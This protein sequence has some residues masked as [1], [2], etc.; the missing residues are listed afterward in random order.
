MVQ[1]FRWQRKRWFWRSRYFFG[2]LA[3]AAGKFLFVQRERAK[4]TREGVSIAGQIFRSIA[5]YLIL[6]VLI[7]VALEVGENALADVTV[8]RP[9][10]AKHALEWLVSVRES[11]SRSV[12]SL[13]VLFSITASVSGVFLGLYFT[14]IS[15]VA[16]SVF[17]RVPGNLR[18]LLLNEKVGNQ[19]IRI[20]G[21]LTSVSVILLGHLAYGGMPGAF[22][23][24]LVIVLGCFG[25]L[26]FLKLGMRAFNFFD[27]ASLSNSLFHKLRNNVWQSSANGFRWEDPSFQA[28]YQKLAERN[29]GTLKSLISYCTQD[30]HME[31][32]PLTTVMQNTAGFLAYYARL[33]S[34]IPSDSRWYSLAP[35][36]KSYFFQDSSQLTLVLETHTPVQPQMVPDQY[37]LEDRIVDVLL[38][39]IGKA[40]ATKNMGVVYSFFEVLQMHVDML[41]ANLEIEK[42]YEIIQRLTKP[43]EQYFDSPSFSEKECGATDLAVFDYYGLISMSLIL[44]F[45]KVVDDSSLRTMMREAGKPT[46]SAKGIYQN[47]IPPAL[48]SRIEYVRKGQDFEK[49]VEKKTISPDW[50]VR[51]LVLIRCLDLLKEAAEKS[52]SL[53]DDFYVKRS[54]KLLAKKRSVLAS[55]HCLRGLEMCSKLNAHFPTLKELVEEFEKGAKCTDLPPP[56]WNWEQIKKRIDDSH[57]K[58]MKVL[59]S[60]MPVLAAL[61]QKESVPDQFGRA[62]ST[63]CQD[64]FDSLADRR[65]DRFVALFPLLFDASLKA[66]EKL[67]KQSQDLQPTS[68]LLLTLEPL[69]DIQSL[70][71]YAMLYSELLHMP[72]VWQSCKATWDGYLKSHK[73]PQEVVKYLVN[74]YQLRTRLFQL[75]PRDIMRTAWEMRFHKKLRQMGLI[76]HYGA[77]E[78]E[79]QAKHESPL[80]R[81]LCRGGFEPHIPPAEVFFVTYL[82]KRPES[83]GI[84]FKD[85]RQLD[86]SMKEEEGREAKE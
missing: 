43:I 5:P 75:T 19:Y 33:R 46:S 58:L 64:C 67:G 49:A 70:S 48:L 29:V 16:G 76:D 50:Y 20:L 82:L 32:A 18:E 56:K 11:I 26:G 13:T 73:K 47:R 78:Q 63:V 3:F 15:V 80:I 14:A 85:R 10:L 37:W 39:S 27:P 74:T 79:P 25:V 12:Q 23:T 53:L 84:D 44:G 34:S 4:H 57:D 83:A 65:A 31:P 38:C 28:H 60:C 17:A 42:G 41:G 24:F 40:I 8:V 54:E 62:Y 51:H 59:A 68:A 35:R 6:S 22:S 77:W 9:I 36:Y 7:A 2:R 55:T 69:L 86:E 1:F 71:G 72:E 81:A 21:V 66:H 52:A 30:Q 45:C 61:D